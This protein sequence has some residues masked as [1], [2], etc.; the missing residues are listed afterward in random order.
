MKIITVSRE[1]GSGGREVGK[2]LSDLLGFAYYDNE[3]I[4]HLARESSLDEGYLANISERGYAMSAMPITIGRTFA[5]VGAMQHQTAELMG[6]QSRIIKNLAKSGDC[7]IVGRNADTLL[8]EYHPFRIFV[9]AD[10]QSRIERCKKRAAGGEDMTDREI[11]R[12][13]R[14]ID[15]GRRRNH[16]MA[17]ASKWGEKEGYEL[18]LNTSKLDIKPLTA[19]V[20]QLA[21]LYFEENKL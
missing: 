14:E 9:Y 18:C 19:I 4:T 7:I 5:G 8:E 15:R 3:I 6:M 17:S 2:R 10:M 16:N 21:Q 13:I 11:E 1:F 12:R 20:A